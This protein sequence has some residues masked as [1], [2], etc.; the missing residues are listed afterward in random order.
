MFTNGKGSV[1]IVLAIA[2]SIAH[3]SGAAEAETTTGGAGRQSAADVAKS[4]SN[5]ATDMSTTLSALNGCSNSRLLL[6]LRIH[7]Q[8]WWEDRMWDEKG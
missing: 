5:P 1:L 8:N 3:P 4:L 2:L 7:F 6:S